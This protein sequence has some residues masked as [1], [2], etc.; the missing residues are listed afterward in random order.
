MEKTCPWQ[1]GLSTTRAIEPGGAN[2]SYNSFQKMANRLHQIQKV[3]SAYRAQPGQR[4]QG[5]TITACVCAVLSFFGSDK[6]V[7]CFQ[8]YSYFERG[9]RKKCARDNPERQYGIWSTHCSWHCSCR[10]YFCCF[11]L[12][13]ENVSPWSLVPF[14]QISLKNR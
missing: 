14:L 11:P 9:C 13:N 10:T 5:E 12:A 3:G 6:G 2:L 7:N 1:K 4:G 8:L